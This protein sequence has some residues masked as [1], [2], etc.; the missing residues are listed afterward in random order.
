MG[1]RFGFWRSLCFS[2]EDK[3]IKN[4][5]S[6]VKKEG[7]KGRMKRKIDNGTVVWKRKCLNLFGKF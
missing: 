4:C 3:I 1:K 2:G 6:I 7:R 5:N